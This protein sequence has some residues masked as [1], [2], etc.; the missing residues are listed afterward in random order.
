MSK[1]ESPGGHL[2]HRSVF[3]GPRFY[4]VCR[5]FVCVMANY[6]ANKAARR[7]KLRVYFEPFSATTEWWIVHLE[8]K[9]RSKIRSPSNRSG[10]CDHFGQKFRHGLVVLLGL[11]LVEVP[12][13]MI[14][15]KRC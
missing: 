11:D 8:L 14:F 12:S 5:K 15:P 4:C 7:P 3:F 13:I 1:L 6:L 2:G 10:F 9:N